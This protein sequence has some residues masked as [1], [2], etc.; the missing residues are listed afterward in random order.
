MTSILEALKAKGPK[1]F[2]CPAKGCSLYYSRSDNLARH[3]KNSRDAEHRH[4]TTIIGKR[5]C[6]ECEKVMRREC[7]FTRH[8]RSKHP[9]MDI[10]TWDFQAFNRWVTDFMSL[11][12]SLMTLLE[13]P[14]TQRLAFNTRMKEPSFQRLTMR[15]FPAYSLHQSNWNLRI[16][17]R[18]CT[19]SGIPLLQYGAHLPS[20]RSMGAGCSRPHPETSCILDKVGQRL[21][22]S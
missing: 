12:T 5:Y 11:M 17:L 22:G 3:I 7:D 19:I 10:G 21:R 6:G 1:E 8:M 13:E 14:V 16:P 20:R 4:M 2:E 9:D 18:P 15:V